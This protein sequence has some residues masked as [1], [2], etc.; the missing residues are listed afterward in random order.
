MEIDIALLVKLGSIVVHT[1]EFFSPD[2][3]AVDRHTVKTLL[4]DPD[5]QAWIESMGPMLPLKRKKR[6]RDVK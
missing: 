3:H 1:D 2:G 5:V 4:R 6:K